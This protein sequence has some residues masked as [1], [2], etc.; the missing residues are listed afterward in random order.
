M[1]AFFETIQSRKEKSSKAAKNE[2]ARQ[3]PR[4]GD[5]WTLTQVLY[6]SVENLLWS[7]SQ[8]ESNVFSMENAVILQT[9]V[10]IHIQ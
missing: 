1:T 5:K 6:S 4:K 10:R 9:I 3:P 7:T 2:K 8:S